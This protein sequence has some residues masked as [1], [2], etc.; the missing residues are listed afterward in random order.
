LFHY[1][2]V[3]ERFG[4]SSHGKQVTGCKPA[5]V[6]EGFLKV[7][8]EA[9]DDFAAPSNLLLAGENDF[10]GLPICFDHHGIRGKNGVDAGMA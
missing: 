3:W 9:V 4:K 8:G 6:G 2:I 5:H 10:S 1:G 7:G